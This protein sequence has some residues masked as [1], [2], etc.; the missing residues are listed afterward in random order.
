[1]SDSVW[2]DEPPAAGDIEEDAPV[3][4]AYSS[5]PEFV[6]NFLLPTWIHQTQQGCWCIKWWEHPEAV[7]RLEALWHA[8]EAMR[9]VPGESLSSWFLFHRDPHMHALTTRETSPFFKCDVA[10][11]THVLAPTWPE[12]PAPA[13]LYEPPD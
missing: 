1:M 9:Q 8:F 4:P 12:E 6:S 5:L 2:D 3:E 11:G 10:K 7:V 13:H